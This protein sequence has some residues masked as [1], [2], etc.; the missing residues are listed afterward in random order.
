MAFPVKTVTF[1]VTVEGKNKTSTIAIL[2]MIESLQ[3][4]LPPLG[5]IKSFSCGLCEEPLTKDDM[6]AN[7][8]RNCKIA[9]MQMQKIVLKMVADLQHLS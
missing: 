6:V 7:V 1:R 4:L 8:H 3:K 5:G 2:Q 9:A